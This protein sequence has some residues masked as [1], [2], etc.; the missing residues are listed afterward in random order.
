MEYGIVRTPE[1]A[2]V[3]PGSDEDIVIPVTSSIALY[4]D[5]H[6]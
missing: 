2:P 3:V 5:G 6:Y 4:S 1:T